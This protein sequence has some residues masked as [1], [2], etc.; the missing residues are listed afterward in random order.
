MA[1]S[2][3]GLAAEGATIVDT[4]ESAG[5]TYPAFVDDM[6]KLGARFEMK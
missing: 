2:I 6:K 4:A 1:L 3:A 5:I